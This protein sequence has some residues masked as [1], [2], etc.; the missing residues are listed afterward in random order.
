VFDEWIR[1]LAGMLIYGDAGVEPLAV[2]I[3]GQAHGNVKTE[4]L[5]AIGVFVVVFV[6]VLL[7]IT[8]LR[9]R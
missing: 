7:L 8:T 6:V 9:S 1:D 2:R 5:E 4:E 3:T